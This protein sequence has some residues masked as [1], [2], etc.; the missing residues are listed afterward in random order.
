MQAASKHEKRAQPRV[1]GKPEDVRA[2]KQS[3]DSPG[4]VD[5]RGPARAKLFGGRNRYAS[6]A[7]AARAVEAGESVPFGEG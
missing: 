7:V 1:R 3:E 6:L 2:S 4:C 5:L